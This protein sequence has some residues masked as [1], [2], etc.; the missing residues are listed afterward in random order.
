MDKVL[1][2]RSIRS[3]RGTTLNQTLL[4]TGLARL[5]YNLRITRDQGATNF[6]V[7]PQCRHRAATL[8]P[9]FRYK[10]WTQRGCT[11]ARIW[12][13]PPDDYI[14]VHRKAGLVLLIFTTIGGG[15]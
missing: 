14:L 1:P 4:Q 9:P 10:R 5:E 8:S 2:A 3:F 11:V 12:L 15:I 6:D 7:E 13:H